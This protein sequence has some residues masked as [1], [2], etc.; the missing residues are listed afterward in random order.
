MKKIVFF[1]VGAIVLLGSC[2]KSLTDLGYSS[3]Y[4]QPAYNPN[5]AYTNSEFRSFSPVTGTY[6]SPFYKSSERSYDLYSYVTDN[7]IEDFLLSLVSL[8]MELISK[9]Y[10]QKDAQTKREITYEGDDWFRI[11]PIGTEEIARV[12]IVLAGKQLKPQIADVEN[13][14]PT[15]NDLKEYIHSQS[16]AIATNGRYYKFLSDVVYRDCNGDDKGYV[17]E[18]DVTDFA[19]GLVQQR[20]ALLD[21]FYADLT[22][23]KLTKK[24]LSKKYGKMLTAPVAKAMQMTGGKKTKTLPLG[25]WTLFEPKDASNYSI[26]YDSNDW[27]KVYGKDCNTP[28]VSVQVVYSDRDMRS[29]ITGV[30]N[31]SRNINIAQGVVAGKSSVPAGW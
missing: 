11:S 7:D 10:S 27:F 18:K 24:E 30:R 25:E 8:R 22:S 1:I 13:L 19:N 29:M 21:N 4:P 14:A 15:E 20:T 9:Y 3:S 17:E 12:R 2:S 6:I 16:N 31:A 23:A 5:S 26:A 28:D